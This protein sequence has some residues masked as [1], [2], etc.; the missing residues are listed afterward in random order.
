MRARWIAGGRDVLRSVSAR[1]M[2]SLERRPPRFQSAQGA[3][4]NRALRAAICRHV[5]VTRAIVGQPGEVLVTAGAQQGR[6]Q[7]RRGLALPDAAP[8]VGGLVFGLGA[9]EL[10]AIDRCIAMLGQALGDRH[11]RSRGA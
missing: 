11:G 2:R 6:G 4:G 1:A 3:Q 7:E 8:A 10:P 5:A 9:V